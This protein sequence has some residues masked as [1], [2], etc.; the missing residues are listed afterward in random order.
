MNTTKMVCL[1]KILA[2]ELGTYPLLV[3][4]FLLV[5]TAKNG[6]NLLSFPKHRKGSDMAEFPY[7]LME[8]SLPFLCLGKL[9]RSFK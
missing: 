3:F 1:Y 4:R 8:I 6:S 5:S 2:V 9:A 7:L